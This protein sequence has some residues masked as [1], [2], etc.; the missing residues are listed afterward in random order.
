MGGADAA[1]G[2]GGDE[3][4]LAWLGQFDQFAASGQ[5]P[6]EV[7]RPAVHAVLMDCFA[8]LE[9]YPTSLEQDDTALQGAEQ[10]AAS[11][12]VLPGRQPGGGLGGLRMLAGEKAVLARTAHALHGL[13]QSLGG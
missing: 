12:L 9:R 2:G 8:A 6:K 1:S 13:L 4:L 5:M 10:A 3:A 7:L 11:D